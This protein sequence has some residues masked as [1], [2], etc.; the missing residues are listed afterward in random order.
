MW[1]VPQWQV[2]QS[3]VRI[4]ARAHA[5]SPPVSCTAS[6]R[7]ARAFVGNEGSRDVSVVDRDALRLVATSPVAERER[8]VARIPVGRRPR[9]V[10]LAR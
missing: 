3:Y 10:A 2:P 7:P 9:G 4:A 1:Q 8:V 5:A 6:A